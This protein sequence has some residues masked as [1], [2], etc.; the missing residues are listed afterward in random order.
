[1][2]TEELLESTK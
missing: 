1:M 2:V